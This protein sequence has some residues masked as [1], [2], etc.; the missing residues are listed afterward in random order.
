MNK[1]HKVIN[2]YSSAYPNPLK[3]R[4]CALVTIAKKDCEWDGWL[5]CSNEKGLQGWVPE[6]YVDRD[7]DAGRMLRDYDATELSVAINS[8]M[9][10][11]ASSRLS[12]MCILL[13][14]NIHHDRLHKNTYTLVYTDT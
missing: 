12:T 1:T 6:S 8:S 7:G 3:L 9:S 11:S 10:L 13:L 14:M 2:A 4:K 5:W